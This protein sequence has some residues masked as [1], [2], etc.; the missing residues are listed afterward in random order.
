MMGI[1]DLEQFLSFK[2]RPFLRGY[3]VRGR[4]GKSMVKINGRNVE[5]VSELESNVPVTHRSYEDRYSVRSLIR[6]TREADV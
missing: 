6:K 5:L 1:N 4:N 2:S 3:L